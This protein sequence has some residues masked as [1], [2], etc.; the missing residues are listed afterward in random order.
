M[1]DATEIF[2]DLCWLLEC[3]MATLEDLRERKRVA[4]HELKRHQRIVDQAVAKVWAYCWDYGFSIDSG[5]F[6]R[7]AEVI[8]RLEAG[9]MLVQENS[10]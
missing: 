3:E 1:V 6:P 7:V 2:C 9:G 4:K 5:S 8:Q 10:P